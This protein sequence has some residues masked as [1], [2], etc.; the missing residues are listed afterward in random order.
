MSGRTLKTKTVGAEI[1]CVS[2]WFEPLGFSRFLNSL[3]PFSIYILTFLGGVWFGWFVLRADTAVAV[4]TRLQA[5]GSWSTRHKD[6]VKMSEAGGCL[7]PSGRRS[8]AL[9][10]A[11][12]KDYSPWQTCVAIFFGLRR[13]PVIVCGCASSRLGCLLCGKA[14]YPTTCVQRG[15]TL[16]IV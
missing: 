7:H 10:F 4:A 12:A 5:T 13:G 3:L 8:G 6:G 2:F 14:R 11:V 16:Q 15:V 1:Q 9:F